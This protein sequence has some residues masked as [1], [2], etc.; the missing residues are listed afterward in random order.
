[1]N[2][3]I[4]M[5]EDDAAIRTSLLKVLESAG[6]EVVLA[7]DGA[8]ALTCSVQKEFDLLLLDLNLPL[9]SG[10]DTFECLTDRYPDVPII[11]ITGLANQYEIAMAAGVGALMEK[12]IEVPV[13][14]ETIR[15]L[16]A[17][18]REER[19]HRLNS[20]SRKTRY[21]PSSGTQLLKHLRERAVT[22]FRFIRPIYHQPGFRT[23]L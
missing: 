22:P 9:K 19:M 16:M 21:I 17:E 23:E 14:L 15:E 2:K 6:F 12:P 1:M 4:L 18:T 13:L 3:R 20:G 7:A 5:V 8:E 11:I 10:W